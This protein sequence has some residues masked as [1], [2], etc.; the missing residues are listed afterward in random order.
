MY[1]KPHE[2]EE[3]KDGGGGREAEAEGEGGDYGVRWGVVGEW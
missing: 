2:G 1:Y 3:R